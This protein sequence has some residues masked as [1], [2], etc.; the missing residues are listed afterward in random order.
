VRRL[1]VKIGLI[2]ALVDVEVGVSAPRRLALAR[3][4]MPPPLNVHVTMLV[5]TGASHTFIDAAALRPLNLVARDSVPYH[6]SSTMGVAASCDVYDVSLVLGNLSDQ[7]LWLLD[8]FEIMATPF[9]DHRH[10]G[11][12]GRD[13]LNRIHLEWRGPTGSLDLLYP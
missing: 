5:D 2:G 4:R 10:H 6:S 8:P 12:L 7:N 9:V 3:A 13:V 1:T 11:L